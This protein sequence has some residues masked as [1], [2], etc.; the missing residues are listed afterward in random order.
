MGERELTMQESQQ[1]ALNV[2]VQFDRICRQEHLQYYLMY[3]TLIG[4]VRHNGF[5]PWD[6]DIDV[7]M[8][9]QDYDRFVKY[10]E[11]HQKELYPLKLHTRAN[12]KGFCFA[13]SRFSDMRY[14]YVNM[15]SYAK[16]F[17]IGAFIDVYPWDNFCNTR[18]EAEKV[19]MGCRKMNLTYNRYLIS[20]NAA[21]NAVAALVRKATRG[22]LHLLKGSH[23][24]QRIDAEVRDYILNHTS[25]QD[26]YYG[27]VVWADGIY[28]F[29]KAKLMDMKVITHE[30]EGYNFNIPAAYDYIL[31]TIY[32][33]YMK[34]PPEEKQHPTHDYKLYERNSQA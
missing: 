12:T 27:H 15:D 6:D 4:A 20:E 13:I 31:R 22:A 34:L 25:D 28:H 17:D 24:D 23:Y 1:I 3:G 14:R 18:E 33:D 10:A 8:P 16:L 32:G 29:E 9:R 11:E 26:L 21:D 19:W 2:L 30:F 5:I 7:M